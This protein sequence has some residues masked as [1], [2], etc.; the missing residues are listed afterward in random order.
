MPYEGSE[1]GGKI[2]AG[3]VT[4][5]DTIS[6]AMG[7]HIVSPDR[8]K[9]LKIIDGEDLNN[10]RTLYEILVRSKIIDGSFDYDA[11]NRV[12]ERALHEGMPDS[13][14][15]KGIEDVMTQLGVIPFDESK[16]PPEDPSTF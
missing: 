8:K 16:L 13:Q 15:L 6:A 11:F 9:R 2:A 1:A 5:Y 12:V 4:L 14:L 7:W 3:I 10:D